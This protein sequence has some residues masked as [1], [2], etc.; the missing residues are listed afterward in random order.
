VLNLDVLT[1]AT[2]HFTGTAYAAAL[3]YPKNANVAAAVALAGMEFDAKEVA[4]I[5]DPKVTA[6]IH[7]VHAEGEFGSFHSTISGKVLP[8]NPC[9]FALAAMNVVS[10]LVER[11]KR[12]GF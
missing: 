4:L 7:E 3:A 1:E 10:E 6:N 9:S 2:A 8:K 12:I 5:A 11:K